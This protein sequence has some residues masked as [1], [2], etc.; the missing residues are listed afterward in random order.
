MST[1][2]MY[3]EFFNKFNSN[4]SPRL[5]FAP[6][7]INLIGEHTDYNGGHV[8][9]AS[10]SFGTYALAARR[11]DHKLRF[12]SMNFPEKGMIEVDLDDL[13]YYEADDWAN[14]PKG[15]IKKM[16]DFGCKID[17]GLNILYYGNIP[18]SASL[19]SSAIIEIDTGDFGEGL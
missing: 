2:H 18:N 6:G 11:T 13:N 19:S 16:R 17:S 1:Q 3:E 15:M 5:F 12:Y 10:I 14:Y 9:P 8:F 4:H 7:R